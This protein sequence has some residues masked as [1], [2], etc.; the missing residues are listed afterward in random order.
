[1]VRYPKGWEDADDNE[2]QI[3]T[4]LYDTELSTT[5][6][7][8]SLTLFD[9]T[10]QGSGLDDTN[11]QIASQLPSTQRFLVKA[12]SA[13]FNDVLAATDAENLLDRA[14][15]ELRINNWRM[16]SAPLREIMS[17]KTVIPSGVTQDEQYFIGKTYPLEN[18]IMIP[19]GTTFN[20]T[21]ETGETAAG[22]STAITVVLHGELVRK[23]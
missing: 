5:A 7:N 8:T 12:I 1:M 11:M 23:R 16:F 3:T 4:T 15:F 14:S 9:N 21:I 13:H 10:E 18:Y 20:A 2:E 17:E 6:A 19:G 22:V